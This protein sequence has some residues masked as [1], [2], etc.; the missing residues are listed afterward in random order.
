MMKIQKIN[1]NKN[2]TN[3]KERIIK[4]A[5][6]VLGASIMTIYSASASNIKE[7][8]GGHLIENANGKWQNYNEI[9]SVTIENYNEGIDNTYILCMGLEEDRQ[10][11]RIYRSF[12]NPEISMV[13]IINPEE[14]TTTYSLNVNSMLSKE[15]E[16]F[17]ANNKVGEVSWCLGADKIIP[18]S[19]ISSMELQRNEFIQEKSR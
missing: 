15:N 17:I 10:T 11:E 18:Y 13:E 4:S 1:N 5:L 3:M 8:S 7:T 12:T 14:Y 19:Q 2:I 16:E 9:V 6:V